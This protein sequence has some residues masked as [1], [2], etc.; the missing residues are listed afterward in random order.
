MWRHRYGAF[1]KEALAMS[2]DR[3]SS[4]I[5][6]WFGRN[7]SNQSRFSSKV[8]IASVRGCILNRQFGAADI[9]NRRVELRYLQ[10]RPLT[11]T[12]NK[13]AKQALEGVIQRKLA[14]GY[15]RAPASLSIALKKS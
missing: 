15:E 3:V 6:I 2:K 12:S 4:N 11:F 13:A 9:R 7:E 10:N 1:F 8:Y 5:L 14:E